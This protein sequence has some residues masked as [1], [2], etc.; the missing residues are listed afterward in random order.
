MH[1]ERGVSLVEV[2]VVLVIVGVL[3]AVVAMGRQSSSRAGSQTVALAAAASYKDSIEAFRRDHGG[4][5]PVWGAANDWPATIQA[6]RLGLANA[7]GGRWGPVN[8]GSNGRPYLD[9]VPE[10]I[11]SGR[12]Q[13]VGS[14]TTT[15]AP[16]VKAR[17]V[18]ERVGSNGYRLMVQR[19]AGTTWK[20]SCQFG[21]QGGKQC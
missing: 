10:G 6:K 17:I 5:A 8:I 15:A 2:L 4:R 3:I 16:S 13:L 14:N 21:T 20:T 7:S 9:R 18:Y 12:V 11:A 19:N 1:D